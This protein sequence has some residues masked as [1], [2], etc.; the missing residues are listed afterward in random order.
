MFTVLLGLGL[1]VI[2]SFG[3]FYTNYA[4]QANQFNYVQAQNSFGCTQANST[5]S[6]GSC[7]YSQ[8]NNPL[9]ASISVFGDWLDSFIIYLSLVPTALWGG[10]TLL[11]NVFQIPPV[12]VALFAAAGTIL[13]VNA[14][15]HLVGSRAPETGG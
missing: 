15:M 5:S 7:S 13:L 2:A 4:P 1:T 8:P 11:S 12:F 6:A 10:V 14:F 3:I 9:F